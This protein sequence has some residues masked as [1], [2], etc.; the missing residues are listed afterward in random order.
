MP[1]QPKR[2]GSRCASRAPP[3]RRCIPAIPARPSCLSRISRRLSAGSRRLWASSRLRLRP[4][5]PLGAALVAGLA[6]A[7]AW[8]QGALHASQPSGLQA[9]GPPGL[10]AS[11]DSVLADPILA[12]ALVAVRIEVLADATQGIPPSVLYARDNQ[13]LEVRVQ[14]VTRLT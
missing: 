3:R 13:T 1:R 14:H 10:H 9:S 6:S 7:A 11:L 5:S 12:R 4:T 2:S 8:R